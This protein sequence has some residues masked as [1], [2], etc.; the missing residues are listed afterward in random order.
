MIL[1]CNSICDNT[2]FNLLKAWFSTTISKNNFEQLI[3]PYLLN[4]NFQF[5]QEQL[6]K[7]FKSI[8][9]PPKS[10]LIIDSSTKISPFEYFI[11]RFFDP[12]PS[13]FY[14]LS[15]FY[16]LCCLSIDRFDIFCLPFLRSLSVQQNLKLITKL[17]DCKSVFIHLMDLLS[18]TEETFLMAFNRLFQSFDRI[19]SSILP[20]FN[21]CFRKALNKSIFVTN[22]DVML[23]IISKLP[24]NSY[25]A[26]DFFFSAFISDLSICKAYA[27]NLKKGFLLQINPKCKRMPISF[28]KFLLLTETQIKLTDQ[29]IWSFFQMSPSLIF[30]LLDSYSESNLFDIWKKL[31]LTVQ[32]YPQI[33]DIHLNI[34]YYFLLSSIKHPCLIKIF[35]DLN[36]PNFCDDIVFLKR[37]AN[38]ILSF[39]KISFLSLYLLF[40]RL[41]DGIS[42]DFVLT[43]DLRSNLTRILSNKGQF[44]YLVNFL[45]WVINPTNELFQMEGITFPKSKEIFSLLPPPSYT[46]STKIAPIIIS[47]LIKI[48]ISDHFND[49]SFIKFIDSI[50][51]IN[52]WER[53]PNNLLIGITDISVLLSIISHAMKNDSFFNLLTSALSISCVFPVFYKS[54]SLISSNDQKLLNF[55]ISISSTTPLVNDFLRI[56]SKHKLNFSCMNGTIVMWVRFLHQPVRIAKINMNSNIKIYI[57]RDENTFILEVR[58]GTSKFIPMNDDIGGWYFIVIEINPKMISMS[59]NLAKVKIEGQ[60]GQNA[61][62]SIGKSTSFYDMQSFH[63]FR[64]E[65][66]TVNVCRLFSLGPNYKSNFVDNFI[67]INGYESLF[68]L[69]NNFISSLY[70]QWMTNMKPLNLDTKNSEGLFGKNYEFGISPPYGQLLTTQK[71]SMLEKNNSILKKRF[72]FDSFINSLD[73][74]GGISLVIHF[75]AEII[76]KKKELH[77]LAFSLF[78]ILVSRFPF[79]HFYFEKNKAYQMIGRLLWKS[80]HDPKAIFKCAMSIRNG[81]CVVTNVDVVRYWL[82][83]P[84]LFNCEFYDLAKTIL[85]SL[86]GEFAEDNLCMLEAADCFSSLIKSISNSRN[87]SEKFL[88][89]LMALAL[90]LTNQNN[91]QNH[92]SMIIKYLLVY[93]FKNPSNEYIQKVRNNDNE[94]IQKVDFD[95]DL[96]CEKVKKK[97]LMLNGSNEAVSLI[98][99]LSQILFIFGKKVSVSL[100][101]LLPMFINSP[102]PV[103][104]SLYDLMM[105]YLPPVHHTSLIVAM[106]RSSSNSEFSEYVYSYSTSFI[107]KASEN[108]YS[109]FYQVTIPILYL[110]TQERKEELIIAILS[111]AATILDDFKE[112]P[113]FIFDHLYRFLIK[114]TTM[115]K[116]SFFFGHEPNSSSEQITP[117]CHFLLKILICALFNLHSYECVKSFIHAFITLDQGEYSI[118]VI[119]YLFDRLSDYNY[120]KCSSNMQ[121]MSNIVNDLFMNIPFILRER[122]VNPPPY[123]PFLIKNACNFIDFY[124]TPEIVNHFVFL[125]NEISFNSTTI[126]MSIVSIVSECKVI[127][128]LPNFKEI[129]CMLESPMMMLNSKQKKIALKFDSSKFLSFIEKVENS[130]VNCFLSLY[131]NSVL[132][133]AVNAHS[134]FSQQEEND[135]MLS[136]WK[137]IFTQLNFPG[138]KIYENCPVKYKVDDSTV[139]Y[140]VRRVLL[141]M[142]PS[143]DHQYLD[144]WET[145]YSNN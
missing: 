134:F 130:D 136:K 71:N 111:A 105:K 126:A 104:S 61:T 138:S 137:E 141:P 81:K 16:L 107:F 3:A 48:G 95:D 69:K 40:C 31:L 47:L 135:E 33:Q 9:T 116:M 70:F 41:D 118:F 35:K 60:F 38:S 26:N 24:E 112:Y 30:E 43:Y 10:L 37:K 120:E 97:S 27:S 8:R 12:H 89:V 143:L 128:S 80:S 139:R 87:H 131:C 25:L 91:A 84:S 93:H 113:S 56:D 79:I 109:Q 44:E 99:L 108:S 92:A 74:I 102:T 77:S 11:L 54:Y 57:K 62:I 110:L 51:K 76:L 46:F 4:I 5:P 86:E 78:E 22:F 72:C 94:C 36:F 13:D 6:A 64:A 121:L 115:N 133:Q 58:K 101:L 82:F 73:S 67:T 75:L 129:I 7:L 2:T 19:S 17:P 50:N 49:S 100:D 106:S 140:Q 29:I 83:G 142:N 28:L 117:F 145:K 125:L 122:I 127:Q 42:N 55:L 132:A 1:L 59:V 66:S 63:F 53:A 114:L 32:N 14:Y 65:L 124:S 119:G 85:D 90:K 23:T 45:I 52:K 15:Y 88:S 21:L 103:L 20:F 34:F 98:H 96:V 68:F 123:I 39:Q 18:K 144:F